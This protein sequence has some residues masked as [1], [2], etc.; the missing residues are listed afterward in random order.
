MI[1]V[2]DRA[3]S[4][5]GRV[6]PRVRPGDPASPR[7]VIRR[8]PRGALHDDQAAGDRAGETRARSGEKI[9]F[10]ERKV[11]APSGGGFAPPSGGAG[12]GRR[13]DGA[14]RPR[15]RAC[16]TASWRRCAPSL[17]YRWRMWVLTVFT[18]RYISS[19]I[20]GVESF[21]GRY[22]R[23][24][25]SAR[26]SGSVSRGVDPPRPPRSWGD[27]IPPDPLGPPGPPGPPGSRIS[28]IRRG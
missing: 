14:S 4:P 25:V 7:R 5:A 27:A 11:V 3:A 19:A 2:S 6:K 23:T 21:V 1:P 8:Q 10:F 15:A 20:S 28:A 26:L 22:R 9:L 17:S 18:D 16:S 13:G 12:Q 24:R